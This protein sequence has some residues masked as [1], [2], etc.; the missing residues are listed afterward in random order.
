MIELLASLIVVGGSALTLIA[1]LLVLDVFFPD[2]VSA[3][4]TV[5]AAGTIRAFLVG[6]VNAFFLSAAILALLAL[7]DRSAMPIFVLPALLLL[8]L[9][10][11]G[12]SIGLAGV[13]LLVGDRVAAERSRGRRLA[14]GTLALV[15][16]TLLPFIGWFGLLPFLLVLALGS[17]IL[18][19][20]APAVLPPPQATE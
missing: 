7:A 3:A 8:V 19:L 13:A 5:S 10:V 20:A 4:R 16:A 11:V 2:R 9:L 15:A 18:S 1:Y 12:L 6:L 17:A 14:Y